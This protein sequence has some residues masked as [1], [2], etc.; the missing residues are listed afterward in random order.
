MENGAGY[1][2][3]N[4]EREEEEDMSA[5]DMSGQ[6]EEEEEDNDN[7]SSVCSINS[8]ELERDMLP[9]PSEEH[10]SS[11]SS[12]AVSPTGSLSSRPSGVDN[13]PANLDSVAL[14][15]LDYEHLMN[16]FES[17]KESSA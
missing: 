6:E 13:N 17:L 3:D 14:G 12:A 4:T 8:E 11:H 15:S 7:C 5:T 9:D 2:I 10:A 16:Y 1:D